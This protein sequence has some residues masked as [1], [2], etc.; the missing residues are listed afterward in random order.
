M[1]LSYVPP[2]E[3]FVAQVLRLFVGDRTVVDLGDVDRAVAFAPEAVEEIDA[4]LPGL[5]VVRQVRRQVAFEHE[6]SLILLLKMFTIDLFNINV[7]PGRILVISCTDRG[8]SPR[9]SSAPFSDCS[10]NSA[11]ISTSISSNVLSKSGLNVYRPSAKPTRIGFAGV[12]VWSID[13]LKE[14]RLCVVPDPEFVKQ[15]RRLRVMLSVNYRI[16]RDTENIGR[17]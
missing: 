9:L 3:V 1:P 11:G 16:V 2:P 12:L 17:F 4:L 15:E 13:I 10:P 7:P 8:N 6:E 5:E 14:V